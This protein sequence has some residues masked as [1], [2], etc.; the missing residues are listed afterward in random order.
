MI[1]DEQIERR[2]AR[3]KKRLAQ[4][5]RERWF[6]HPL[7]LDQFASNLRLQQ[8]SEKCREYARQQ[9]QQNRNRTNA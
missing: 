5:E 1:T 4:A 3:H 7:P 8:L 2:I 6:M 9:I